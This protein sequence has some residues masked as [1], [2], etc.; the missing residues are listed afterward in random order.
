MNWYFVKALL[1]VE[2]TLVLESRELFV[3][4]KSFKG[5]FLLLTIFE[6]GVDRGNRKA[7]FSEKRNN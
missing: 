4:A 5:G 7:S 1:T 6:E 2:R 3:H